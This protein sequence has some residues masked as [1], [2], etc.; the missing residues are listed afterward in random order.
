MAQEYALLSPEK[1]VLQYRLAG[2]GTRVSAHL[3]DLIIVVTALVVLAFGVAFLAAAPQYG[4]LVEPF[5][6]AI[7]AVIFALGPIFYFV[8]FEGFWNGQTLGKKAMG[9]RVRMVDG[10]PITL[11]AAFARNVARFGDF[12]PVLYLVGLIAMFTNPRSQRLGDMIAGTV[13]LVERRGPPKFTPAPH[14]VSTHPL[15]AY[16]GDLRGMTPE[17]Y[18]ALR[19]MCDRFPELSRS[20]QEKVLAEVWQPIARRRAVPEIPNVHPLYV[21]EAVVMKYGRDHGLL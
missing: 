15:E 16:V 17:E 4:P 18:A 19:R 20:V 1:A 5:L 3:L 6:G 9:L 21:A 12:F 10:T 7:L 13:V 2:I 11:G 14:A 8:L